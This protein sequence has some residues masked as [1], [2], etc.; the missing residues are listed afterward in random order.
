MQPGTLRLQ[1][2]ITLILIGISFATA[3]YAILSVLP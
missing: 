1:T 2:K 3:V